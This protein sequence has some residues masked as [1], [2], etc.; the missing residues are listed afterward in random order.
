MMMLGG[1]LAP[2]LDEVETG[3]D[4]RF[5][6]RGLSAG[7]GSV[8][9]QKA[10]LRV[11][12]KRDVELRPLQGADVGDVL[13]ERGTSIAGV[14]LNERGEPL[15]GA[16][17]SV[18][19]M[20]RLVLNR[21][22]D[23]PR[24]QIGQEFGQ[25]ATT[26]AD[27]HFE[28]A[29]LGGGNYTVHVTADGYD[30]LSREDVPAGARDLRLQPVR[31]GSLLLRLKRA[32]DGAP[33][34]GATVAA[35]SR[36]RTRWFRED[37]AVAVLAGAEALAA[38]GRSGDPEGAYL[39]R[40]AGL[41]GTDLI[42]VAEGY[43]RQKVEAPGVGSGEVRD[44]PVELAA[45]AVLAGF[46]R[47]ADGQPI[48]RALVRLGQPEPQQSSDFT[49]GRDVVE[50][51]FR[52]GGD[53]EPSASRQLTRSGPDGAFALRGVG[54]GEWE[55]RA[56][57][58]GYVPGPRQALTVT[59]AGSQQDIVL[60]LQLAGAVVGAV[61]ERDGKPVAGA[62]VAVKPV[63]A[64]GGPSSV[65]ADG[66]RGG[67]GGWS[68]RARRA[69]GMGGGGEDGGRRVRT[70]A[71]GRYRAD[72]LA[73]GEYEVRLGSDPLHGGMFGGAIMITMD[74]GA[75]DADPPAAYANVKAGEDTLVD[76]VKPEQGMLSGRVLAGGRPAQGVT[77]TM[78]SAG[79]LPFGGETAQTDERGVYTFETVPAGE[80]TL[81]AIVPGAVIEERADVELAA[82]QVR[83]VDLVFGGSTLAGR[84][85]GAG[86]D[87]GV[88]G[89]TLTA[90]PMQAEGG[91]A[92]APRMSF[93][94]MATR[95]SGGGPGSGMS[96]TIGGGPASSVRTDS[97]GRFELLYVKPGT[98]R[99]EAG[100][101]GYVR[102]SLDDVKVVDGENRDDLK[103]TVR[104]G[105]VVRGVVTDG[106]TGARL[107]SVPVRLT[108]P[109]AREMSVTEDGNFRFEGLDSGD[110]TVSVLGS[111][112]GSSAIASESITLEVGED[113]VL[114]L[115]TEG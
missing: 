21:I 98:Y 78:R 4:G 51:S 59:G 54:A 103:L 99:I 75:E 38:A 15:P 66:A 64:G 22:E 71:D 107:D 13:L 33:V 56:R 17:V 90:A 72:G 49:G 2:S 91:T 28:L 53:D 7:K 105:A 87:V 93:E 83:S 82:G 112:F 88:A 46:V 69:F 97:E 58:Q 39:V 77:V 26:D 111:G 44:L 47:A 68:G 95:S 1:G 18:S 80:Y 101:E 115:K 86:T 108:G 35:L 79:A 43:A 36:G 10:G 19:S 61:T 114:D 32:S 76:L 23:L 48:P 29:G 25:R 106:K 27:G 110:Y 31:L 67:R 96:M 14:V 63:A 40:S 70:G 12:V 113:R 24:E 109:A 42:V 74:G 5:T 11:A 92:R 73:A 3:V 60:V 62:E 16:D 84:V 6:V 20:A 102:S 100:G 104:R 57:A 50:R 37:R 81:S 65:A 34:T 85:V 30:L 94:I 9:V 41:E 52:V 8:T 89:L 55:L 45:E